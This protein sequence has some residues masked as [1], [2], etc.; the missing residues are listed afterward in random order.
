[1]SV[2]VRIIVDVAKC[3]GAVAQ[4]VM[5]VAFVVMASDAGPVRPEQPQ[6]QQAR[7]E[8]RPPVWHRQKGRHRCKCHCSHRNY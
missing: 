3:L 2:H 8:P 4:A 5:F 7:Y 6:V 1:M